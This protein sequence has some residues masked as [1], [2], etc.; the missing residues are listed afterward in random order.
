[1]DYFCLKQESKTI[2]RSKLNPI[3]WTEGTY[4]G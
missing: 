2:N 3:V 1:M 4:A